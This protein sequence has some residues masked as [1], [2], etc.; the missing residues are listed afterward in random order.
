MTLAYKRI[1]AV[2]ANVGLGEWWSIVQV[3]Y[4][5][6]VVL[7]LPSMAVVSTDERQRAIQEQELLAGAFRRAGL[8]VTAV[9][10]GLEV[11]D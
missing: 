1:Q 8:A 11:K 6:G 3:P 9:G 10:S 5:R 7:V 2:L 4:Y